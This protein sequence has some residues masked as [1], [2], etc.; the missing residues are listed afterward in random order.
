MPRFQVYATHP[1]E[2]LAEQGRFF[3]SLLMER[4]QQKKEDEFR[5]RQL[6][7][8][9]QTAARAAEAYSLQH[10]K[11]TAEMETAGYRVTEPQPTKMPEVRAPEPEKQPI[12]LQRQP[13][14]P[15]TQ[16]PRFSEELAAVREPVELGTSRHQVRYDPRLAL[17]MAQQAPDYIMAQQAERQRRAQLSE[18]A[19]VLRREPGMPGLIPEAFERGDPGAQ[20]YL[21]EYMQA[22]LEGPAGGA[23]DITPTSRNAA[24]NSAFMAVVRGVQARIK[25]AANPLSP[26]YG[27]TAKEIFEG[28][29]QERGWEPGTV[30]RAWDEIIESGAMDA[31]F[32]R[33]GGAPAPSGG[34]GGLSEEE[35][36]RAIELIEGLD[37]GEARKDL[38]TAE[39][40]EE[41]IR[42]ILGARK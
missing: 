23:G 5:E 20:S 30:L 29:E 18:Y 9:E 42:R 38:E 26:Y 31:G 14:T 19:D 34:G 24:R 35:V 32:G 41:E 15:L 4:Q 1:L 28:Y 39:Y 6:A 17:E 36:A 12:G 7:L 21:R 11:A 2:G 33:G 40:S 27:M 8:Q 10:A 16:R 22:Q 3:M 13:T 37:E 25:E